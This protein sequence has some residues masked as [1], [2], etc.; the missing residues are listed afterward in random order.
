MPAKAATAPFRDVAV[1]AASASPESVVPLRAE[2]VPAVAALYRRVFERT[3]ETPSRDLCDTFARAFLRG[4]GADADL[5]SLVARRDDAVI[6]FM[7]RV[8]LRFALGGRDLRA[9]LASTLMVDPARASAL[10]GARLVRGFLAGPQDCSVGETASETTEAMWRHCGGETLGLYSLDWIRV[11]NPAA[12]AVETLALRR[13][14]L[15]PLA[16]AGRPLAGWIDGRLR[17]RRDGRLRWS[18]HGGGAARPA[19]GPVTDAAAGPDELA[20]L[21]SGFVARFPLRPVWSPEAIAGIVREGAA[22]R[23]FGPAVHRVVRDRRGGPVGAYVLH[24]RRGGRGRVLQ[25]FAE[26]RAEDAVLN[27]MMARAAD[28]GFSALC[29]RA[30]PWQLNALTS[31]R[32]VLHKTSATI[33]HCRDPDVLAAFRTGEAFF[34]G[35]AGEGWLR[36]I[37]DTFED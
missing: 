22:K 34:N 29:G 15:R 10:T 25:W 11:V 19:P 16:S 26:A 24:G 3:P 12:L 7:G 33:V 20:S 17:A 31:R 6:G 2:D 28:L 30:Q 21:A 4:S 1:P 8:P 35:Y 5:P 37:G 14:S 23:A 13:P 18:G 9:A 36:L 32:C 27:A